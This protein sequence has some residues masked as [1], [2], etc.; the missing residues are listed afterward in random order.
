MMQFLAHAWVR[1]PGLWA[2]PPGAVSCSSRSGPLPLFQ[3]VLWGCR[4]L[5][6]GGCSW[7]CHVLFSGQS[8]CEVSVK[9]LPVIQEMGC[10]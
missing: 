10:C 4:E 2:P 1:V 5:G 3:Q 6:E 8:F 7:M 9:I